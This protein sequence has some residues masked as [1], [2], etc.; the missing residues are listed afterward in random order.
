MLTI[1]DPR[2]L[3]IEAESQAQ[4]QMVR[5]HTRGN[6]VTVDIPD[7]IVALSGILGIPPH[8]ILETL[9]DEQVAYLKQR[10]ATLLLPH[11]SKEA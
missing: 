3:A 1:T 4:D 11:Y 2:D 8:K 6:R 9:L 10:A 5:P 7:E